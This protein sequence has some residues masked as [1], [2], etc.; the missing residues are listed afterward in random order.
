MK[1]IKLIALISLF[2]LFSCNQKNSFDF[3][4]KHLFEGDIPLSPKDATKLF[5]AEFMLTKDKTHQMKYQVEYDK[6]LKSSM[7]I[8]KSTHDTIFN[9]FCYKD[10]RIWYFQ[11]HY[12]DSTFLLSPIKIKDD[13][14]IGW[15]TNTQGNSLFFDSACE[16]LKGSLEKSKTEFEI[17]ATKNNIRQT[18]A[19]FFDKHAVKMKF[20]KQEVKKYN[21]NRRAFLGGKNVI[22][23]IAPNMDEGYIDVEVKDVGNYSVDLY[24]EEGSLAKNIRVEETDFIHIDVSE[25]DEGFYFMEINETKSGK[26]LVKSKIY[27]DSE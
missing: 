26:L 22:K 18:T 7:I 2:S 8:E 24:F 6:T 15:V 19:L 25:M 1:I 20:I 17:K 10:K 21:P 16:E 23:N 3:T 9:G 11:H 5:S 12:S 13:S 4:P 14:L 27:V